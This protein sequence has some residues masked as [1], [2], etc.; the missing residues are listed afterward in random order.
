MKILNPAP[1]RNDK[2]IT[3]LGGAVGTRVRTRV[4]IPG[5]D[6]TSILL[7]LLVSYHNLIFQQVISPE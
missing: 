4:G 7:R 5:Y 3:E 1:E 2:E 6:M